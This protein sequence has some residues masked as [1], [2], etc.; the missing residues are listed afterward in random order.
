VDSLYKTIGI[1][2]VCLSSNL[3][4]A[5]FSDG[6]CF[7]EIAKFIDE[8]TIK[9]T[10]PLQSSKNSQIFSIDTNTPPSHKKFEYPAVSWTVE[11]SYWIGEYENNYTATL[12]TREKTCEIVKHKWEEGAMTLEGEDN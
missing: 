4:F 1:L 3:A 7:D 11:G 12:W 10:S 2:T 8:L 9:M 6:P 5:G